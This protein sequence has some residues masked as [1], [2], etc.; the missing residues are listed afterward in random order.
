MR[1]FSKKNH[2]MTFPFAAWKR[3]EIRPVRCHRTHESIRGERPF[4]RSRR[5]CRR[6][7]KNTGLKYLFYRLDRR[8][9]AEYI[10]GISLGGCVSPRL[11]RNNTSPHPPSSTTQCKFGN[12]I[13]RNFAG[14]PNG[15]GGIKFRR[16]T[17]SIHAPRT[18][19][20]NVAPRLSHFP[21][22]WT[23]FTGSERGGQEKESSLLIHRRFPRSGFKGNSKVESEKLAERDAKRREM[24]KR[25]R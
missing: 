19:H 23:Y 20:S 14:R 11:A 21:P 4:H 13:L 24:T 7:V 18:F 2:T 22:L 3:I 5:R 25:P 9:R 12:R 10:F 17:L 6:S 16:D 8:C 1:N 15:R